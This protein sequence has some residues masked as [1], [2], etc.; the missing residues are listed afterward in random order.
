MFLLDIVLASNKYFNLHTQKYTDSSK[1]S[2]LS[3]RVVLTA[4]LVLPEVSGR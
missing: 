2:Y 1:R 3:N 4:T